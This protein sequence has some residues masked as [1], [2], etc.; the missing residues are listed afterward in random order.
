MPNSFAVSGRRRPSLGSA[1]R[2]IISYTTFEEYVILIF[3]VAEDWIQVALYFL[4]YA[5]VEFAIKI[6]QITEDGIQV[7]RITVIFII[8]YLV[9]VDDE[10]YEGFK[11]TYEKHYLDDELYESIYKTTMHTTCI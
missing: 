9:Y 7:V 5:T 10:S 8:N 6:L 2:C 3:Q 4:L 1:H 11:K